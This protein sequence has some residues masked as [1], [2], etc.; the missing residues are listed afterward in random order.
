MAIKATVGGEP[1]S[2][3]AGGAG[4][5]QEGTK[6]EQIP[7]TATRNPLCLENRQLKVLCALSKL[8]FLTSSSQ[9]GHQDRRMCFLN[10]KIQGK[11]QGKTMSAKTVWDQFLTKVNVFPKME[12]SLMLQN[13]NKDT[14]KLHLTL[15]L[16][17]IKVVFPIDPHLQL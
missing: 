16:K 13:S 1:N 2:I 7:K 5:D 9:Q 6:K 8:G 15:P 14:K 4:Q 17:G 11:I 3:E 12:L 10:G